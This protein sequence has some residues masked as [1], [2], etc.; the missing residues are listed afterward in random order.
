MQEGGLVICAPVYLELLA[1]PRATTS[2][3]ERFLSDT[4]VEAD[5]L[6]DEAVWREAG[7]GF[8]AHVQRRRVSKTLRSTSP[9]RLLVDFVVGAH[10]ALRADRLF[11]LDPHRYSQDFPRLRLMP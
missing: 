7:R 9:K 6:L 11:T 8:V 3:V 1:H 10:A 2:F 4:A 5:F